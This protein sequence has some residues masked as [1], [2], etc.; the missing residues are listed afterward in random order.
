MSPNCVWIPA[1]F[2]LHQV[3]VF[4]LLHLA[5]ANTLL[6]N[7]HLVVMS[8]AV[9]NHVSISSDYYNHP[10]FLLQAVKFFTKM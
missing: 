8:Q 9:W 6:A 10:Q 4:S 2:L 7:T 5:V 3:A 1:A